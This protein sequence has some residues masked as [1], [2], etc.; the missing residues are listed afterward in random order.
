MR[1]LNFSD[2]E[3]PTFRGWKWMISDEENDKTEDEEELETVSC[4]KFK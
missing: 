4:K 3:N 1:H 2:S